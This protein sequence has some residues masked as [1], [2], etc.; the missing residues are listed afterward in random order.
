MRA[1]AARISDLV[2]EQRAE[3]EAQ[4]L[5]RRRGLR[6][7]AARELACRCFELVT[8]SELLD[9]VEELLARTR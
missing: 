3:L 6:T 2:S 8:A 5:A 7:E 9:I 4:S 1:R